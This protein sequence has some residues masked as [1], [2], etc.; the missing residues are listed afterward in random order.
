MSKV[1]IDV[2]EKDEFE[3]EHVKGS[4]HVPLSQFAAIAP[5]I[6]SELKG[7]EVHI[8]CRSGKRAGLAK[9][10]IKSMGLGDD[11][12]CEVIPGGILDWKEKG[13][14]TV[15]KKAFH[16]PI[17][18]QVQ[19]I[20]GGMI[21]VTSILAYTSHINFIFVTAFMGAGLCFAGATGY[22]GMAEFL[23]KMPWNRTK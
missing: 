18:R 14:P 13:N 17:L 8:M 6:L 7:Q 3:A 22:C 20:S 1:I 10:Q 12:V 21:L 9:D 11:L 16:L 5:K 4:L 19:L 15:V 23:S 2:R